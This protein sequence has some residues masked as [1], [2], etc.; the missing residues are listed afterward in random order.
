[1]G[2]ERALTEL[3][4]EPSNSG[5]DTVPRSEL[6]NSKGARAR[7]PSTRVRLVFPAHAL[8]RGE[9]RH[10][11][12]S[13]GSAILRRSPGQGRTNSARWTC[14]PPHSS[15]VS[16]AFPAGKNGGFPRWAAYRA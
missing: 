13:G 8:P 15:M 11:G 10:R 12:L 3:R 4:H 9:V 5:I 6:E 2:W 16:L 14:T 7:G 1:M